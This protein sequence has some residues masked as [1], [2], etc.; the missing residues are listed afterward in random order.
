MLS[1]GQEVLLHGLLMLR[2]GDTRTRVGVRFPLIGSETGSSPAETIKLSGC[3][4]TNRFWFWSTCR[5]RSF[6]DKP[7]LKVLTNQLGPSPW[8]PGLTTQVVLV[9]VQNETLSDLVHQSSSSFIRIQDRTG[10]PEPAQEVQM[11]I[12]QTEPATRSSNSE[13]SGSDWK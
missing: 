10:G 8:Q 12:S 3:R 1:S 13:G 9:P 11:T 4:G 6:V 2:P 7:D 5:G